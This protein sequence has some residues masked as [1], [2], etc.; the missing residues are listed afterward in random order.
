MRWLSNESSF[1]PYSRFLLVSLL[2]AVGPFISCKL[3]N[4][5]G[6]SWWWALLSACLNL[7]SRLI[8]LLND[9]IA[10]FAVGLFISCKLCM[11]LQQYSTATP[12]CSGGSRWRMLLSTWVNP[13]NAGDPYIHFTFY[14]LPALPRF[15]G[16]C[17]QMLS[18]ALTELTI[19]LLDSVADDMWRWRRLLALVVDRCLYKTT[20]GFPCFWEKNSLLASM[21]LYFDLKVELTVGT[22]ISSKLRVLLL[23]R[24]CWARCL[25]WRQPAAAAP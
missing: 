17:G 23:T 5:C 11:F 13:W 2:I 20:L 16:L 8:L 6:G 15:R 10:V 19:T 7:W 3:C 9:I 1:R 25:R 12:L 24:H 21:A 4:F 14:T 22:F 18:F